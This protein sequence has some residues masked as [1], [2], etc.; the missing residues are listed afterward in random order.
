MGLWNK[1][2][3]RT[4]GQ[5]FLQTTYSVF[6]LFRVC[7]RL[8][9]NGNNYFLLRVENRKLRGPNLC[10]NY[11]LRNLKTACCGIICREVLGS[12][13]SKYQ[14]DKKFGPSNRTIKIN[15]SVLSDS[16]KNPKA[17]PRGFK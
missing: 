15:Q 17:I 10:S 12:V 14:N 1:L 2:A 3:H 7:L 13:C 5:N 4:Y 8:I 6:I 11:Y 16:E 9:T